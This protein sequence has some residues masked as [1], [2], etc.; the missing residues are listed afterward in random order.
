MKVLNGFLL[1]LVISVASPL[2]NAAFQEDMCDGVLADEV[3]STLKAGQSLEQIAIAAKAAGVEVEFLEND[4]ADAEQDPAAVQTALNRAGAEKLAVL[5][6][7]ATAMR[8]LPVRCTVNDQET[9]VVVR[10]Q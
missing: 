2:S 7:M 6:A 4:L 9:G 10:T 1:A 3:A 8:V 5:A